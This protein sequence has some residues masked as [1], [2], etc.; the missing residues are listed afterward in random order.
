MLQ[1]KL[2]T[3]SIL[4]V[5]LLA[6][7]HVGF[8]PAENPGDLVGVSPDPL[9]VFS[10]VLSW[11]CVARTLVSLGL[12]TPLRGGGRSWHRQ[13]AKVHHKSMLASVYPCR[14]ITWQRR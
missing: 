5:E 9:L 1:K 13:G 14:T 12:G 6:R 10:L 2:C 11:H 8:D 3:L 4:Q 7:V